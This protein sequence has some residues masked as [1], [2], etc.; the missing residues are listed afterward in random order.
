M[1]QPCL[2]S[3]Y[4][5]YITHHRIGKRSHSWFLRTVTSSLI[6]HYGVGFFVSVFVCFLFVPLFTINIQKVSPQN[7]KKQSIL[8]TAINECWPSREFLVLPH[9]EHSC[10]QHPCSFSVVTFSDAHYIYFQD[11]SEPCFLVKIKKIE[12]WQNRRST[13]LLEL[14]QF[15]K[16][17]CSKFKLREWPSPFFSPFWEPS[18]ANAAGW[19]SCLDKAPGWGQ[20]W[21]PQCLGSFLK[22]S[23]ASE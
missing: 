11:N 15:Y 1:L 13:K 3:R 18:K 12:F 5:C 16:D 19:K 21:T 8:F 4:W 2:I 6:A 14:L 7:R 17:T 10:G 20:V 22:V 9:D 23:Q